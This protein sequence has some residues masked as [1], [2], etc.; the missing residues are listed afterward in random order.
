MKHEE[1]EKFTKLIREKA[2][3]IGELR[4]S[5]ILLTNTPTEVQQPD[6]AAFGIPEKWI[7]AVLVNI[8]HELTEFDYQ[9]MTWMTG[10]SMVAALAS[11]AAAIALLLI[12]IIKWI[13]QL[14]N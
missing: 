14:A 12:E 9:R 1:I 3:V 5:R 11:A 7:N 13:R 2:D 4:A 8:E 6:K 10:A